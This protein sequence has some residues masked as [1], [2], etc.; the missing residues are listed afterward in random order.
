MRTI[1][2]IAEL[3][4][5]KE[6]RIVKLKHINYIFKVAGLCLLLNFIGIK[7]YAQCPDLTKAKVTAS[8]VTCFGFGNGT[9][10]VSLDDSLSYIL[11]PNKRFYFV[12]YQWVGF[13]MFKKVTIGNVGPKFSATFTGLG[14]GAY[15][16][17]V[18]KLNGAANTCNIH[19][20][21]AGNVAPTSYTP[22]GSNASAFIKG[23]TLLNSL[24][25]KEPVPASAGSYTPSCD[26]TSFQLGADDPAPLGF[27]A[28]VGDRKSTRLNSSHLDL[29]RMPSSA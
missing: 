22:P 11:N 14:T 13:T 2:L 15:D 23:A 29:S 21:F 1:F 5:T 20:F 16:I 27:P 26:S 12:L 17:L 28:S 24:V 6:A 10:K 9:I 7:S 19:P 18:A 4:T 25:I 8:D 3:P